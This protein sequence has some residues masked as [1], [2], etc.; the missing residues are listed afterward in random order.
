MPF[1]LTSKSEEETREIA[2]KLAPLL[3]AGDVI[4]LS[5]D[6]GAGKTRF[7]QGLAR[8][9]S[10]PESVYVNSPTFTIVNEYP[11]RLPMYHFDLYRISHPDELYEIGWEDYTAGQ[12]VCLVE[13]FADFEEMAP[14]EH[15]HVVM[16][17]K[18]E[19]RVLEFIPSG[20]NWRERLEGFAGMMG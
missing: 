19:Q 11:G 18:D 2:E 10:V 5:G 12:G 13:W 6:L 1:C 8:G 20:E 15:L 16:S 3:K 17:I 7:A 4:G 14:T 9:L